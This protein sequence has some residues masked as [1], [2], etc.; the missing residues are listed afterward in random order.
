VIIVTG[1]AG[2]IG[3]NVIRELNQRRK[4][5]ILLVD[6]MTDGHKSQNLADCTIA[7][8]LDRDRCLRLL[9]GGGEFSS[10]IESVYHLGACS[11]TTQWDG[12]YMMEANFRFSRALFEHC[13][14]REVPLV[15]ASSAAVYGGSETFA[16]A[17]DYEAPLNMYGY[18]KLAFDQFVRQRMPAVK[19]L[20]IGLR[21]FNVYGPREQHKGRMASVI[22]HLNEQ[23]REAGR[24]RLFAGSHGYAA[25]EQRRDFVH[26]DDVVAVTLWCMQQT[27][28][29]SGI[30]NCGTGQAATFNSVARAIVDWYGSG[31]IDYIDFPDELI[32]SYQ[33]YTQAEMSKLHA[34]GY[35]KSF[36]GVPQGIRE[37]LHWL[38]S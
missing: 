2:F 23:L 10:P 17:A 3:S 11:D 21:Y 7:D 25:G 38:D 32:S 1:G 26:V 8:Y 24:L 35:T 15:Y 22:W 20:V 30:Y 29:N 34:I 19:S 28:S 18:S 27:P 6:D 37:Y 31:T 33:A 14:K 9:E 12:H 4:T 13:V 36:K 5:E 16:E